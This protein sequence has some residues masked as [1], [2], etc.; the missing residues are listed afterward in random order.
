VARIG[1]VG[2]GR[3]CLWLRRTDSA[4]KCGFGIGSSAMLSM[5]LWGVNLGVICELTRQCRT[6]DIWGGTQG[7]ARE[8]EHD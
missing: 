5:S 4:S 1:I 3:A 6:S 2:E 7:G 8:I